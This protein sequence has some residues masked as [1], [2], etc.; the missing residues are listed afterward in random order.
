M[1]TYNHAHYV[2]QSISSVLSQRG[3]DIEMLIGDDGS[4]DATPEC[5]SQGSGPAHQ[6]YRRSGESW[7]GDL[8]S[9]LVADATGEYVAVLNSDDYWRDPDKL[10]KQLEIAETRP[11][12]GACFTSAAFIDEHGHELEKSTPDLWAYF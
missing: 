6:V 9:D 8:L 12:L 4:T 7:C 5:H 10:R 2:E 1:S 11:E 3:V